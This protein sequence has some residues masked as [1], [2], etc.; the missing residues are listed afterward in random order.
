VW[1]TILIKTL[2][3]QNF[4]TMKI[5]KLKDV[6]TLIVWIGWKKNYNF[7]K[8]YEKYGTMALIVKN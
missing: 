6:L 5:E 7:L 8:A 4:K 2:K 3:V 1:I